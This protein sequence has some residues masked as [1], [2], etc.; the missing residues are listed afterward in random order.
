MKNSDEIWRLADAKSPAF[1]ALSDRI[2][3]EPE[4]NYQE[5][6]AAARHTEMLE[7][8]GF[9]VSRGIA[10]LPTALVGEAEIRRAHV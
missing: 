6:R 5:H 7:R 2:W 9:R 8:E 3:E 10:G 4:L 1:F